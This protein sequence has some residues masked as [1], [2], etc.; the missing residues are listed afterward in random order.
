MSRGWWPMPLVRTGTKN[1]IMK[2]HPHISPRFG[3]PIRG[4]R[5]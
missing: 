1:S 4:A 3:F 2:D 5:S